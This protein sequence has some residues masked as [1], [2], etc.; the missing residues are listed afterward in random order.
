V[1]VCQG[2]TKEDV[3]KAGASLQAASSSGSGDD[4][5]AVTTSAPTCTSNVNAVTMTTVSTAVPSTPEAVHNVRKS[6][7]LTE[8]DV[9]FSIQLM[10]LLL[11]YCYYDDDD[12]DSIR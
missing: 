3:E 8:C 1:A 6:S 9:S 5:S 4:S 2:V 12:D 10:L 7:S 11:H